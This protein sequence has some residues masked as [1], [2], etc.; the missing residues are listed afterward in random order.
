M[1]RADLERRVPEKSTLAQE[2][3]RYVRGKFGRCDHR[4]LCFRRLNLV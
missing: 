3:H 4:R 1:L 2:G